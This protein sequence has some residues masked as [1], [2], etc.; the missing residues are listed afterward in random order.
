MGVIAWIALGPA[1]GLLASRPGGF[2]ARWKVQKDLDR[3]RCR[4]HDADPVEYEVRASL[5]HGCARGRLFRRRRD[6]IPAGSS[7]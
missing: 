2:T 3:R 1:A 6:M 7:V 5:A 4:R